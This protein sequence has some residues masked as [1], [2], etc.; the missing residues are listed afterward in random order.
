MQTIKYMLTAIIVLLGIIAIE[1][2]TIMTALH[3]NTIST[4]TFEAPID[5][6]IPIMIL[7]GVGTLVVLI[8]ANFKA[9]STDS[10]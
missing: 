5:F 1:L 3:A 6:G 2:A 10:K 8:S 7:V 9:R 4:N